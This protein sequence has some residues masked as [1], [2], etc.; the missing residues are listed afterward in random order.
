MT[1]GVAQEVPS[2]VDGVLAGLVRE[3][4]DKGLAVEAVVAA[5]YGAPP[6]HR[7]GER[8]PLVANDLTIDGI[9]SVEPTMYR[10]ADG[11]DQAE[12]E[13]WHPAFEYILTCDARFV[14][15]WVAIRA[16]GGGHA[17]SRRGSVLALAESLLAGPDHLDRSAH[18]HGDADGG[19][20]EVEH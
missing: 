16:E 17:A 3:L 12:Q 4:V 11:W 18:L 14:V 2:I 1:R 10:L 20:G 9:G 6:A 19:L 13:G 5:L 15:R 7:N 8:Y